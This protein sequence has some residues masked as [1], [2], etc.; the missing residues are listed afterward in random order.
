MDVINFVRGK[1]MEMDKV[2]TNWSCVLKTNEDT[3]RIQAAAYDGKVNGIS[4][5]PYI[6]KSKSAFVRERILNISNNNKDVVWYPGCGLDLSICTYFSFDANREIIC[7]RI[8]GNEFFI[9]SDPYSRDLEDFIENSRGRHL[10]DS[11]RSNTKIICDEEIIIEIDNQKPIYGKY[12]ELEMNSKNIQILSIPDAAFVYYE[13]LYRFSIPIKW[14]F[15]LYMNDSQFIYSYIAK[16]N[17]TK[18]GNVFCNTDSRPKKYKNLFQLEKEIEHEI[19]NVKDDRDTAY[20]YSFV[21]NEKEYDRYD[22]FKKKELEK[23]FLFLTEG[24]KN[25]IEKKIKDYLKKNENYFEKSKDHEEFCGVMINNIC[26]ES[27]SDGNY[28]FDWASYNNVGYKIEIVL[29]YYDIDD[30]LHPQRYIE[31]QIIKIDADVELSV[32]NEIICNSFWINNYEIIEKQEKI[33]IS[34]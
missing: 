8:T 3:D 9:F 31:N 15:F 33:L 24:I 26:I 30:R 2:V 7:D 25:D 1:N 19:H 28:Y 10:S 13:M 20:V 17:Y 27:C 22:D 29:A 12:F 14:I 34:R 5:F 18:I 4:A 16:T 32:S 21:D 23:I 11:E 6:I